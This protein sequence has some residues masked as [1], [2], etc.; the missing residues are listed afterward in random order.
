[1]NPDVVCVVLGL[2]STRISP[3]RRLFT[4]VSVSLTLVRRTLSVGLDSEGATSVSDTSATLSFLPLVESGGHRV[5]R[6]TPAGVVGQ[7]VRGQPVADI[8]EEAVLPHVVHAR[9]D[10]GLRLGQM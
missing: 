6:A 8:P 4:A 9:R 7:H 3:P 5:T 1:M 2:S 10:V